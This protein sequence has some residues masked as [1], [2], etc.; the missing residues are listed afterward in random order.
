VLLSLDAASVGTS[1]DY[2]LAWTQTFGRGRAF[3]TAL[4]H[5]QATWNDPRFQEHIRG[6][7]KWAG[8]R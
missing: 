6:A 1:G 2:P 7:V 3:Y 4:G 5:F 8:N